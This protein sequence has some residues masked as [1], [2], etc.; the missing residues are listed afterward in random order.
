MNDKGIKEI[1]CI[2]KNTGC[3]KQQAIKLLDRIYCEF[4]VK[5][6]E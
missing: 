5:E 2:M 1:E 6:G 3:D 4:V